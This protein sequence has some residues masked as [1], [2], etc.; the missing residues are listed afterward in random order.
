MSMC[1]TQLNYIILDTCLVPMETLTGR[2]L[3]ENH[4]SGLKPQ[5]KACFNSQPR[6]CCQRT[7][8][9][10]ICARVNAAKKSVFQR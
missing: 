5:N 4:A 6:R 7:T 2:A 8:D 1:H 9:N 10:D 3:P